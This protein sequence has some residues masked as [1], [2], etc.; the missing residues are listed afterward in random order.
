[1]NKRGQFY[2]LGAIVIIVLITSFAAISNYTQKKSDVKV[3]DFRD[4]LG[5]ESARVLD[6]GAFQGDSVQI[7]GKTEPVNIVDHFIEVYDKYAGEDKEIYFIIGDSGGV[8]LITY[9]EVVTGTT[10]LEFETSRSYIS[11]PGKQIIEASL[12]S[13]IYTDEDGD[14]AV[15]V[16]IGDKTYP[17]KIKPG[18]N[19]YFVIQQDVGGET[20]VATG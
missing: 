6:Y 19:F 18:Q 2:L 10:G 13:K 1:M 5:I 16:P 8:K 14:K 9:D 20:H 17:F 11:I 12:D 7:S 15:S 3:F 4:E